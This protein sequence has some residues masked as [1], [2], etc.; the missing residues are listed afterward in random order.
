MTPVLVINSGSSSFKYQLIDMAAEN[1][2]AAGLVERIGEESGSATHTVFFFAEE[3]P[4][5]AVRKATST[6]TERI[7]DHTAGF[8]LMIRAFAEHGPSLDDEPPI[9]VGHRVVHGGARFFEPT[10]ITPLVEINIDELSV[11]APLHNPANLQGITAAKKA[12][13]DVPHV[14]VFDTAFHQTLPA[15]AYTYA[16][17]AELAAAHRV[18][19][20]GFHGTSHK[21]VSEA[22]A[23]F[24]ERPLEQLRQI[25]FHLGN[26][27]SVAAI[28]GGRS[29]DTSM[30]LTPLEGLVMGTRSG[31]LDPAVLLHLSRRAGLSTDDLDTLLNKRS[32]LLGLAGASDMRDIQAGVDRGDETATR[33]FEVY[34]HRLRAYAGAYL[35]QL[36]GVDVI[37][38][39]AGVGENAPAVRE[40][41][42]ATLGFAGVR[43]DPERN[44]APARGIRTI[45]ADDSAVTVLVVPTDEELEIARQSLEVA[46][47]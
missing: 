8:D 15:A 29:I 21:F 9:A 3:G 4:A 2:L 30:G 6:L 10:L 31:D 41:A 45:S 34:I 46:R 7:P 1:V 47:G 14:A 33:A 39:T 5:P 27:A 16:I 20:Y 11:L 18:R 44:A 17:D 38:F 26:G 24:L 42:L 12:F 32:G 28:D 40:Q 37:V 25:V 43:I 23:D 13:P 22:A 19:R 36:G 35:A